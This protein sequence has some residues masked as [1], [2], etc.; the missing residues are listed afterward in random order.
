MVV[1]SREWRRLILTSRLQAV[2]PAT[3]LFYTGLALSVS[4][5]RGQCLVLSAQVTMPPTKKAPCWP[6]VC[7]SGVYFGACWLRPL[8]HATTTTNASPISHMLHSKN[9]PAVGSKDSSPL[10]VISRHESLKP[11]MAWP[12]LRLQVRDWAVGGELDQPCSRSRTSCQRDSVLFVY[13]WI[14]PEECQRISPVRVGW[15]FKPAH[16]RVRQQPEY[17]EPA[18]GH[19][20][21]VLLSRTILPAAAK[22]HIQIAQLDST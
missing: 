22:T 2:H 3:P 20:F 12:F 21:S 1:R 19:N 10:P 18:L 15:P 14:M 16:G 11:I 13:T 6:Q 8:G 4:T 9:T 5:Y 17:K 7:P